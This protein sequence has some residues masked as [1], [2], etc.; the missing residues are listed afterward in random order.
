MVSVVNETFYSLTP[1]GRLAAVLPFLRSTLTA[2]FR[3]AVAPFV[4][5]PRPVPARI[6]IASQPV[7]SDS[8]RR[9]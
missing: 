6:L 7:S 5:A 1:A 4:A 9:Q 8:A 2:L 3:A